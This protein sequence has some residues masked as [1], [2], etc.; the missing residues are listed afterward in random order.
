MLQRIHKLPL[1][2]QQSIIDN[3]FFIVSGKFTFSE[4]VL[5]IKSELFIISSLLMSKLFFLSIQFMFKLE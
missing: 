1:I 5:M 2:N 3:P 4:A